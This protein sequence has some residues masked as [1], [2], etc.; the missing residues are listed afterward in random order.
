MRTTYNTSPPLAFVG[1]PCGGGGFRITSNLENI[2]QAG[3]TTRFAPVFFVCK[4][5]FN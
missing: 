5:I 1:P 3:K 2:S 4:T